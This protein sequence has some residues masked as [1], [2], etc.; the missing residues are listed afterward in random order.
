ML[1]KLICLLLALVMC[2]G[3]AACGAEEET[4]ETTADTPMQYITPAD[5]K[6][7]LDS[8]EYVF[9]DIRKAADSGTSTVPGAEAWD[10]DAAKEGDAE[11]GKATMTEAT[12]DLDKNIILV[13]YSGKRYAQAATNALSAI[14]YDMSKVFT[15]EGGFTAWSETYPELVETVGAPAETEA[16]A[17]QVEMLET[18]KVYASAEWVKSVIDGQ[19]PESADYVILE[20]AWG[21]LEFDPAYTEAHVPGAVHMNTDYIEEEVY[22]NI[23]TGEEIEAVCAQYGITKDTCVIVYGNN[24]VNSADDRVAFAMLWAGVENVKVLDGGMEAWTAAGYETESGEN[25]PVATEEPFGCEVPAH[26]EYILTP[27]EV[28]D[29]IANDENFRLVSIRSWAEFTG[30]TSGY[31]YIP[32]AGEPKGAI[33]GHDTDDGS[34]N[35]EDGTVVDVDVLAGY[36]AES[37]ASM[38]NE[39]AFYCGTGWRA[40]MPFLLAYEEG[41]T[42]IHLYDGGWY[43][44]I[45]DDTREVQVGDPAG[46]VVYTTV[47]ELSDDKA[48]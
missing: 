36:L 32:K 22:W 40:T 37:G 28:Q 10:M 18:T 43:V 24:G 13:C 5:A 20:C 47:S 35:K 8:D 3:F 48:A 42:N 25:A 27:E 15:L 39:L 17:A 45:M 44:W 16:P 26:P 23:R 7:L 14:G 9:F 1:K 4:P 38:D 46:D 11:A 29:K 12:K 41:Y 34:Y 2:M 31:S 30:E 21:E 19:Q 6:E 33:W